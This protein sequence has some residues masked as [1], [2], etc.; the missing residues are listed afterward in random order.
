MPNVHL[1]VEHTDADLALAGA[2]ASVLRSQELYVA[3][4]QEN[5][6]SAPVVPATLYDPEPPA[7]PKPRRRSLFARFF[8]LS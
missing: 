4:S 8:G 3:W 7:Q 1:P 5:G 2:L 6:P